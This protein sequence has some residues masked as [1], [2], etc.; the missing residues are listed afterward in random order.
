MYVLAKNQSQVED[1]K[2]G[3]LPGTATTIP[4]VKTIKFTADRAGRKQRSNVPA[5]H[6]SSPFDRSGRGGK[7]L[8]AARQ[9][10]AKAGSRE[11]SK[12]NVQAHDQPN[13][14]RPAA[15]GGF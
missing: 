7:D 12:R 1:E 8:R 10:E 4:A 11:G 5:A 15:T 9:A 14:L 2:P 6:G 13:V 3:D